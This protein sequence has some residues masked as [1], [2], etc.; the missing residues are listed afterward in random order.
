MYREPPS[1]PLSSETTAHVSLVTP[2]TTT[3][4]SVISAPSIPAPNCSEHQ[5][6]VVPD[7]AFAGVLITAFATFIAGR[8]LHWLQTRREVYME[9]SAGISRALR[10]V[11]ML[12]NPEVAIDDALKEYAATADIPAKAAVVA[13]PG[14]LAALSAVQLHTNI[15]FN[16]VMAYRVPMAGLQGK[17]DASEKWAASERV[18]VD[19]VLAL[20]DQHNLEGSTDKEAFGLLQRAFVNHSARRD[21]ADR[22]AQAASLELSKLTFRVGREGLAYQKASIPLVAEALARARRELGPLIWITFNKAAYIRT[23]TAAL[24]LSIAT[25]EKQV[26]DLEAFLTKLVKKSTDTPHCPQIFIPPALAVTP[27]PSN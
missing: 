24:E 12:G 3:S 23:Q 10:A 16:A 14:L 18:A 11:G 20:M 2:P 9:V 22:D 25:Y 21:D 5:K 4:S 13:W 26:T 8:A 17:I 1:H 19:R 6:S 15:M 7:W 27:T